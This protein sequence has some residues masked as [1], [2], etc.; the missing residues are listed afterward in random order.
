MRRF[1][2]VVTV[3]VALIVNAVAPLSVWAQEASPAA[4]PDAGIVQSSVVI[5]GRSLH[6]AC[7][8]TGG[9][10][11]LFEPG[12]PFADGGTSIVATLGPEL[13][14]AL[15]TRFCAYDRA[16]TGGSD[17]DPKGVRT[18]NDDVADF[19]AVL[20]SPALDCPCV[21]VGESLG[22]SIAL[23]ALAADPSN[24][25][26]LVL[27]D[28]P[29]PGYLDELIGL[30]PA[31][32]PEAALA[33]DPYM[34]GQNEE[35]LDLA[36]GFRQVVAP[37]EPPGIPV[38]VVTH[39]AGDPPGCFPCSADY[40]VAKMEIAWQAGQ[41]ALA[42]VLGGRLVVA[43]GTGHPIANENPGLVVELATEVI[44]AV[45]DPSSWATPAP[46]PGT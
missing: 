3:L 27:L 12:G 14:A 26:G 4:S 23:V 34:T 1:L 20:A 43:D 45:R 22:G 18:L 42:R 29:Y 13:A 39:G 15:G 10:A 9:P 30:A 40:P 7:V 17:P 19:Q 44:A 11:V 2:F 6:T 41:A 31:G 46:T 38:V 36:A 35:R 37:S 33:S 21:V 8:G 28:A 5:G 24:F 32:A 25:A 16:G